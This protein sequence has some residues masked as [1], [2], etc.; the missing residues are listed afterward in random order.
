MMIRAQFEKSIVKS[1]LKWKISNSISKLFEK[2]PKTRTRSKATKKNFLLAK[3]RHVWCTKVTFHSVW[4]VGNPS[5][6][7]VANITVNHVESLFVHNVAPIKPYS[8]TGWLFIKKKL[9]SFFQIWQTQLY[10]S[11]NHNC[12]FVRPVMHFQSEYMF[13]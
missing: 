11:V 8:T 10:F 1:S 9:F 5:A 2:L 12:K 4:N 7:E 3:E 13:K 6:L